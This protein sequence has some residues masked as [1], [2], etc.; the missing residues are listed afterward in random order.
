MTTGFGFCARCGT[1]RGSAD[2]KFCA[3]CGAT[4]TSAAPP[5]AQQLPVAPPPP[6][7][8]Q[9]PQAYPPPPLAQPV[10]PPPG[11]QYPQAYPPPPLAQP[12]YPPPPGPQYPQAYGSAPGPSYS[13]QPGYTAG[14]Q[15][16]S[17]VAVGAGGGI[18]RGILMLPVTLVSS[19]L[20]K[21]L[22]TLL[23]ILLIVALIVSYVGVVQVP[24]LTSAFGMDHPR[25]LHMVRDPA[26]LD[27][28]STKWGIDK[29]SPTQNYTLSANHHYSGSVQIDDTISEGAIAARPEFNAP[30]SNFSQMQFRIHEGSIEMSAFVNVPGYP[31]SGPVYGNFSIAVTSPRTVAIDFSE[32]DFGRIG[33]PGNV[34]ETVKTRLNEYVNQRLLEMGVTIDTLE[35]REGAIRF[36]GTWPKTI[37]AD[38]AH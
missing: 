32:L 38:P 30:D 17:G 9:Y 14:V 29:P 24:V 3:T 11:P 21:I 8:P 18:L 16:V 33:V 37:T 2:V 20:G 5:T 6:P 31:F 35:L 1:P 13:G 22:V 4:F 25:D 10:Y 26:A 7:G 28:L 23:S 36:K 27:A 15:A 12:V 34:V 19:L